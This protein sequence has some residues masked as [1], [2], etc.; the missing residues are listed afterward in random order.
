M[1]GVGA[2]GA[3]GA[4]VVQLL[5]SGAKESDFHRPMVCIWDGGTPAAARDVGPPTHIE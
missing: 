4:E 2:T 3:E 1:E 5:G